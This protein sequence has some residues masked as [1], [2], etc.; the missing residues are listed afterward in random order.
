MLVRSFKIFSE[1]LRSTSKFVF[2]RQQAHMQTQTKETSYE[3]Y[4]RVSQDYDK[5]RRVVGVDV[6]EN[7]VYTLCRLHQL[8][9]DKYGGFESL[10]ILDAGCGTGNYLQMLNGRGYK[11]LFGIDINDG[12]F[13]SCSKKFES[14]AHVHL[15]KGSLL[16]LGKYF[17]C[18]SMDI[19]M[20]NQVIHHLDT[21]KTRENDFK[22]IR[23]FFSN[24]YH[25]LRPG[26]YFY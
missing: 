19:V 22:N 13:T 10:Q 20:A 6:I 14:N 9:A 11:N 15:I 16:D 2:C 5:Y 23:Q 26:G 18:N 3:S 4:T 21:G 17:D 25:I 24:V 7:A 8:Q 1:R 12:M